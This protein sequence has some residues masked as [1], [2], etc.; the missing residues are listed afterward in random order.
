MSNVSHRRESWPLSQFSNLSQCTDP[1]PLNE[2]EPSPLNSCP[3]DVAQNVSFSS[4]SK[5]THGLLPG[6]TGKKGIIRTLG[7]CWTL[8]PR[9][10][11]YHRGPAVRVGAYG[12]QVISGV[13]EKVRLS[14]PSGSLNPAWNPFLHPGIDSWIHFGSE[15]CC[16]AFSVHLYIYSL[17]MNYYNIVK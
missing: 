3:L 2:K 8:I 16:P 9:D 17:G 6:Y 13:L 15:F 1:C 5:G 4:F 11:K 12:S 10:L 7:E 14:G